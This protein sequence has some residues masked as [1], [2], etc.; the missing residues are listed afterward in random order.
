VPEPASGWLMLLAVVAAAAAPIATLR[1]A[2]TAG[3]Q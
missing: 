3:A 2:I 1:R